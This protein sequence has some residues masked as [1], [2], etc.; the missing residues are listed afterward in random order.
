MKN[1]FERN[2]RKSN[3]SFEVLYQQKTMLRKTL[4]MK[5]SRN[6]KCGKMRENF[7]G[8]LKMRD[9]SLMRA[10][11]GTSIKMRT[12]NAQCGTVGKYGIVHSEKTQ[13]KAIYLYYNI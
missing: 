4:E 13:K 6:W 5:S 2:V 11:R 10:Y 1:V 7:K 8:F 9:I 12:C 3:T